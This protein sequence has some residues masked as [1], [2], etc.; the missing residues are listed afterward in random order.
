MKK[1]LAFCFFFLLV[2]VSFTFAFKKPTSDADLPNFLG[3]EF[4]EAMK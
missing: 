1:I 3:L 2:C 4:D